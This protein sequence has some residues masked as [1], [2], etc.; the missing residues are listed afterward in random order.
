MYFFQYDKYFDRLSNLA[1]NRFVIY[2]LL[3][4]IYPLIGSNF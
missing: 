3:F 2:W 1:Q 4:I